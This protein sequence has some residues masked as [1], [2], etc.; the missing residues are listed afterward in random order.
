MDAL[1]ERLSGAESMVCRRAMAIRCRA[2]VGGARDRDRIPHSG[3]PGVCVVS[4]DEAHEP[5]TDEIE[6]PAP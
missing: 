1:L 4:L 2:V 5:V 6:A 3:R